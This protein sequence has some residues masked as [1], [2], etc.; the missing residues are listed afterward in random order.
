[1]NR[2][3]YPPEQHV[4]RDLRYEVQRSS[5]TH[6]RGWAPRQPGVCTADGAMRP[7]AITMMVDV[8]AASLAIVN[9]APDW[10]ATADLAYWCATPITVGPAVCDA[11]LVRAG[12]GT[13]VVQA[14]VYDAGVAGWDGEGEPPAERAGHARLTFARIPGSASAANGR[15]DRSAGP[16]PRQSMHRPESRFDV[17]IHD[18][19]G[20]RLVDAVGGVV[21]CDKS[22]YV[23]NS[24]GTINGGA[25]AVILEA[26]AE[27]AA[28][29]ATGAPLVPRDLQV[30]YLAQTKVG[31]ARTSARVVRAD[32][33][34]AVV[35]ATL[36]DAGNADLVLAL[37]T[38][39]LAR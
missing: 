9:A 8:A 6:A 5:A 15:V 34:H 28:R 2:S 33:A 36:V 21:E 14:D 12:S 16:A 22:D 1:M 37:A 39:V 18:K 24:F 7:A 10:A 11:W 26:A 25:V 32:E 27:H 17:S 19:C 23:R 13:I 20:L 31:P 38:A 3:A 4:L 35:E 29:A 30:H